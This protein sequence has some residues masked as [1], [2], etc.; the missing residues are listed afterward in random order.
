MPLES[1]EDGDDEREAMRETDVVKERFLISH[2]PRAS[3]TRPEVLLASE[4]Y[5]RTVA[6]LLHP[7]VLQFP[8]RIGFSEVSGHFIPPFF[9]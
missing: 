2:F 5:K 3:I 8:R 1:A 7:W 9:C 4:S 6:R